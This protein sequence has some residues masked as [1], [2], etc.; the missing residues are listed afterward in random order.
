MRSRQNSYR[1]VAFSH[2]S[3]SPYSLE[4]KPQRTPGSRLTKPHSST[5]YAE[6]MSV[7]I[8]FSDCKSRL[9]FNQKNCNLKD[10]ITSRWV[11]T[12][13]VCIVLEYHHLYRHF[14]RC[15]DFPFCDET[16]NDTAAARWLGR[17]SAKQMLRIIENHKLE[18]GQNVKKGI[19][20]V[21][22]C[23][24]AISKAWSK[25][26]ILLLR[27]WTE[28]CWVRRTGHDKYRATGQSQ[29]ESD[30]SDTRKDCN[31]SV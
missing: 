8:S 13:Y 9:F 28:V 16:A 7:P 14:R 30:K 2:I 23:R 24:G 26:A 31:D 6:Y 12:V 5:E 25:Q 22:V 18:I 15:L 17:S 10:K 1:S 19:I 11:M 21:F 29:E 3:L 27:T 4:R 20:L